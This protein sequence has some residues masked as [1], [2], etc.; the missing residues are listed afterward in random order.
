M[1]ES[2]YFQLKI[3]AAQA[4]TV[5]LEGNDENFLQPLIVVHFTK[6]WN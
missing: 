4:I 2:G 3:A 1:S 5:K 6:K